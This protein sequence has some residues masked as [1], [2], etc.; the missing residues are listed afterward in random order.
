MSLTSTVE[1]Y[2]AAVDRSDLAGILATMTPDCVMHYVRA[3]ERYEGRD[4]G[5]KA[6]FEKRN[7]GVE[8][9]WHGDFW[10]VA[11]VPASRVA[12][13]FVV[14]RTDKGQPERRGDNVNIFEFDG[15]L[16]KRIHVWRGLTD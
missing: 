15:T 3:G 10:H 4:T 6:Y 12:T 5:V 14:R 8:K 9:S 11:D 2:F 16:I 7:A 1:A 13:R